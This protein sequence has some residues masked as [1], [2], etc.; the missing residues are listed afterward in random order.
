MG[1]KTTKDKTPWVS[2]WLTYDEA[3]AEARVARSTMDE[4]RQAGRG[5]VFKKQLNGR[6]II[7]RDAL[8]EW[9]ESLV[10]A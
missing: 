2:S 4:W 10:S 5:P 7:K 6:L 8:E 3:C 1:R 9:I